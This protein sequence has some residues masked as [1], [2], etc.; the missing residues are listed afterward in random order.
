[1]D[2]FLSSVINGPLT[3]YVKLRAV[4][5]PGMPGTFSPPPRISDPDMYHRTW[6]ISGSLASGFIWSRLRGKR[7]RYSRCMRNPEFYVYGK[8]PIVCLMCCRMTPIPQSI[9][10]SFPESIPTVRVRVVSLESLHGWPQNY[11]NEGEKEGIYM[12]QPGNRMMT[13][14]S[15]YS[16]VDMM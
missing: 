6:C 12:Y 4:H 2:V 1:M 11:T 13:V 15:R 14:T 8:R 9:E 3:R 10:I 7:S 5:A 16:Q